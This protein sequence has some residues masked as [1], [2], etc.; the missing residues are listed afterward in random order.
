MGRRMVGSA[1]AS[2]G[3]HN[4]GSTADSTAGGG[5]VEALNGPYPPAV[6]RTRAAARCSGGTGRSAG[7]TAR[8]G[9]ASVYSWDGPSSAAAAAERVA[10][11]PATGIADCPWRA[12]WRGV[13]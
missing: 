9:A 2:V 6:M 1:S 7:S 10:P 3:D 8:G 5:A 4:G 13:D 11:C 12:W